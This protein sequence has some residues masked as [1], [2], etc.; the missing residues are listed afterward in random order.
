MF[1]TDHF[2]TQLDHGLY[3]SEEARWLLI[4]KPPALPGELQPLADSDSDGVGRRRWMQSPPKN[5]PSITAGPAPAL[6]SESATIKGGCV[7]TSAPVI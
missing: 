4:C 1:T 2:P 6:H 7:P 3:P 5:V